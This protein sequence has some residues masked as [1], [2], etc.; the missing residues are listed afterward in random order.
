MV[1]IAHAVRKKGGKPRML[2]LPL[3]EIQL[4]DKFFSDRVYEVCGGGYDFVVLVETR[5]LL[6]WV[7][8]LEEVDVVMWHDKNTRLESKTALR[9]LPY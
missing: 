8:R 7:L 1:N 6:Q 4:Y 9:N 3:G 5:I 2:Y